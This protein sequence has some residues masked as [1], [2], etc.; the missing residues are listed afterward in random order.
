MN[1][2]V[3]ELA[4]A[5]AHQGV[6][7]DIYTRRTSADLPSDVVVEPGVRVRHI[8]AGPFD[9]TKEALPF[10]I[11]QFTEGVAAALRDAP[12]DA[13]HANYWLS[14]VAGHR[15]KHLLDLPL[16][17]TFHTLGAVKAANG[18]PEPLHRI[19]AEREVIGCSDVIFSSCD[20]ERDQILT[21]YGA[22]PARLAT[23]SPGV[24]LA[25]FS[26]GQRWAARQ[27]LGL[28]GEA[29]PIVVFV[30]RLQPLKGL[31]LAVE[32]IASH[33]ARPQLVVVGG[34]S[35]AEGEAHVAAVRR[36]AA[37]LSVLDRITWRPPQPHHLLSTYYRAA[38]A[39]IVP[40]RS[41]SFGLVA[42]EAAACGT[43]VVATDVGG[44]STIV[45]D[46]VSGALVLERTVEGF[47]DGLER[48]LGDPV[49]SLSM[50]A[51][52]GDH[53]AR[54]T[55]SAA[56]EAFTAAVAPTRER[57]LVDCR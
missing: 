7:C 39:A 29:G 9:L 23:L 12:V 41:E 43:P 57:A 52:A 54:F 28:D 30:G 40:S 38:D 50:G 24:D 15:L 20:V 16:A 35:G 1:V 56:A 33:P 11:D 17:V 6:Q 2:Y 55:W 26:P 47:A 10:V 42:L 46:G 36:R 21:H 44:L 34:P 32:A 22:D 18:D 25:L 3:R 53:A 5:L 4:T 51:A 8:D 13:L 19:E 45:L 37:E 48:V 14:A 27:A 49:T 31:D